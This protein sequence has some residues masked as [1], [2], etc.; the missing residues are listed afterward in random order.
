MAKEQADGRG[1]DNDQWRRRQALQLAAQLPDGRKDQLA[2]IHD[3]QWLVKN[4]LTD[5]PGKP[6][7]A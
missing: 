5:G 1:K 3:L 4:Y 6:A 2:I 7:N